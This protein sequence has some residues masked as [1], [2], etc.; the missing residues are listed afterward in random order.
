MHHLGVSV[1]RGPGTW[2]LGSPLCLSREKS[3]MLAR[4]GCHLEALGKEL[5]PRS[6]GLLTTFFSFQLLVGIRSLFLCWKLAK[7]YLLFSYVVPDAPCISTM[8]LFH[9][10]SNNM[11]FLAHQ[12]SQNSSGK[13][14]KNALLLK[15]HDWFGPPHWS[16]YQ[17]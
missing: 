7:G 15:V 4:E 5:L 16:P 6:F 8:P 14:E 10:I 12:V 1:V 2:Q 3:N 9:H 11:S 13:Q 17:F